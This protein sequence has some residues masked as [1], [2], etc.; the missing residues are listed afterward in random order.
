MS[1][2]HNRARELTFQSIS[3]QKSPA[4]GKYKSSEDA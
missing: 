2:N 3:E 1:Q 4:V